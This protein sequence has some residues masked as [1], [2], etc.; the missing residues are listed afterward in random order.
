MSIRSVGCC[1]RYAGGW[2][3]KMAA[4]VA[5]AVV[6]AVAVAVGVAVAVVVA[7]CCVSTQTSC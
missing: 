7:M 2:K 4:A 1:K 6:V 5:A 3:R